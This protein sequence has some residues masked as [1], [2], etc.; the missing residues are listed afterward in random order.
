MPTRYDVSAVPLQG[1]YIAKQCPVKIQWNIIRPVDKAPI[2]EAVQLRMQG[3]IDFEE[4]VAAKLEFT[5]DGPWVLIPAG[6]GP[7]ETTRLTVAAMDRHTTVIFGGWLPMDLAGRRTGKPDLLVFV[8]DGYVPV[9]VKHHLTLE[10]AEDSTLLVSD[11]ERPRP[12]DARMTPGV[13]LRKNKD[14]ALQLAHYRRMLQACGYASALSL[15]GILG[16]EGVIVWY[17]LDEPMWMTPAKSDGKKQKKRTSLDAYDF[18]FDFRLDI[19]AVAMQHQENPDIEL[20]VVPLQCGDCPD[21]DWRDYCGPII[22]EGT[23]SPTLLPGVAFPRWAML[24]D[25]GVT[26]RAGVAGLHYETARLGAAGVDIRKV[27]ALAAGVAPGITVGELLPR[28]KKQQEVLLGAGITTAGEVLARLDLTT[29]A[30][31][32]SDFAPR[33]ILDARAVLGSEP[34]YRLPG[35]RVAVDRFNVEIDVDM[36]NAATG[37][38]YLWGALVT[39]RA[40][41]GLV[42]PGYHPFVTWDPLDG[43]AEYRV[44]D[45]FWNWLSRMFTELPKQGVTVGAFSWTATETT[46]MRRITTPLPQLRQQIDEFV[47]IPEWI[48]LYRVYGSGWTNGVSAS[49]KPVATAV[50][51]AWPVDDPGGDVSMVRHAEAMAGD[52]AARQWLLDYNRGDVE[53][54]RAVR[55]WMSGPGQSVPEVATG[56]WRP[57]R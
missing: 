55:E 24:R 8:G 13:A 47:A 20:I 27:L 51:F 9:D 18:E 53:A 15:A 52:E 6:L 39:D 10:E 50:G 37:E 38:V 45:E 29:A 19:A 48:D 44:F 23:G 12:I 35:E 56:V 42:E 26:D 16:K 34:I 46:Q 49:L 3:G 21:C 32:G 14:D 28:S 36:E 31:G 7:E 17:D 41:T 5:D 43:P 33:A 1:G 11:L 57:G 54:T 2:P 4:S 22:R 40:A 30:L 25:I